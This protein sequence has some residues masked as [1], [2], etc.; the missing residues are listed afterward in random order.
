[1]KIKLLIFLL[2]VILFNKAVGQ[3]NSLFENM[4]ESAFIDFQYHRGKPINYSDSLYYSLEKPFEAIDIRFGINSFG[5]SP[6][7]FILKYPNYGLGFTTYKM[8]ASD[9]LGNPLGIYGFFSSPLL[10]N[11][12]WTLGW[13]LATGVAWNFKKFDLNT[14]PKND[15]IGSEIT[16]YFNLKALFTLLINER[17]DLTIGTDFTHFSNGSFTTPNKG[18]NLYGMDFGLRY[19]FQYAD[20]ALKY[21]DFRRKVSGENKYGEPKKNIEMATWLGFGAK[22]LVNKTYSGPSYFC[23]SLSTDINRNYGF[24]GKYGVGFDVLYDAS[25][26]AFNPRRDTLALHEFTIFGGHLNH[27]FMVNRFSLSFQ[28]GTYF[29]K[30]LNGKGNFFMRT[31]LKYNLNK[32]LFINLSLKSANGMIA[33]YIELGGGFRFNITK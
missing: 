5:R 24:I 9:T 14:N 16:V 12:E 19:H 11:H 20:K 31:G 28:V 8:G 22:K 13:E 10:R 7:D 25:M 23:G 29:F 4:G 17:Y 32:S 27:E 21:R 15:L 6:Q 3:Y 1:M 2:P 26:D 30:F 33:D 18:M